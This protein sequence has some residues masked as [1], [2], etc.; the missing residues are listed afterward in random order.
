[1]RLWTRW[2]LANSLGE[3]LGLGSTFVA[4]VVLFGGLAESP[5]IA[6]ILLSAAAM[7]ATGA[8][9][10]F[11]VGAAQWS[12]LRD[13]FPGIGRRSWIVATIVGAVVAWFFGST[14]MA[15]AG[16]SQSS[17]S[18]A[19]EEPPQGIILL[20]AAGMGLVAG[21]ILSAAQW[22]VLRR[23]ARKAGWWLPANAMAWFA[24]MPLIFGGVDLA[25]RAVSPVGAILVMGAAIAFAGAMVGAIHGV[26]LVR[27]ASAPKS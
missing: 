16:L 3:L 27:L 15:F 2:I 18:A 14:T 20:M 21:L 13:A 24:G 25:Q 1:M 4:G 17:A 11:I 6:A 19:P 26:A 9:E 8:L 22:R 10:G 5:G 12:V 23:L 7:T